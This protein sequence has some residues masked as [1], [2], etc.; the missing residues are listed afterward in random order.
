MFD[1]NHTSP[2]PCRRATIIEAV[3]GECAGLLAGEYTV[4]GPVDLAELRREG[5]VYLAVK[6]RSRGWWE[7][8]KVGHGGDVGDR[9]QT[10]CA[11]SWCRRVQVQFFAVYVEGLDTSGRR[12]L[13]SRAR[14]A[15]GL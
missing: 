4:E 6:K 14:M 7:P 9:I 13:E 11:E 2:A 10:I 15:F 3:L 8:V 5:G 1:I 12:A